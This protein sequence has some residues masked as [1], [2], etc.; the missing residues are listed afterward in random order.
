ME[1]NCIQNFFS[2]KISSDS[3]RNKKDSYDLNNK[4]TLNLKHQGPNAIIHSDN[5]FYFR[6][7]TLLDSNI[8][9]HIIA[10]DLY[11]NKTD[12]ITKNSGY[13]GVFFF[14]KKT[15]SGEIYSDRV[16][17]Y[18][19]YFQHT[20]ESLTFSNDHK[21]FPNEQVKQVDSA[22]LAEIIN[23]RIASGSHTFNPKLSQIPAAQSYHFNSSLKPISSGFYWQP[24][25]RLPVGSLSLEEASKN[26]LK[27]INNHLSKAN[28]KEKKVAVLLS[29]GVDSSLL[30]ALSKAH[31]NNIVAVTPVFTS[32]DNPELDIAKAMAASINIEHQIIEINDSDIAKEFSGVVQCLQQP[33]RSPH[34]LIFSILMKQ[35]Q[36][37]FD[38]V[39]FGEGADT[40]FGYHGIKQ[41]GKRYEKQRKVAWLK[42]YSLLLKA[43]TFIPNINKLFCLINESVTTQVTNSWS[44]D[45]LPQLNQQLPLLETISEKIEII[46]WLNLPRLNQKNLDLVA[47]ENLVRKFLIQVGNV[48]HFYNMGTIANREGIEL[49]CPFLDIE[50][51]KYAA[52]FHDKLYF[53]NGFVKPILRSMG[54]KFYRKELMY[55]KK[56]GF[57][58]PHKNWL[59]GPLLRQATEAKEFIIKN[60]DNEACKDNEFVWLIMALQELK[61]SH[62]IKH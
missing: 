3:V 20:Q 29:G 18:R 60:Y 9:D 5:F 49:I 25:D 12:I 40:I 8:T 34:A 14:N 11:Q 2:I 7:G 38:A 46:Q 48:D 39:V 4:L 27:L 45:Y 15:T 58:V 41:A 21:T 53:G 22:W 30:A 13:F 44:L 36:G 32:G 31:N 35:F 50:L 28:I 61:I 43:L 33:I 16:G 52:N 56:K 1:T 47:F 59:H 51:I 54:A 42:P 57:P 17:I 6:F 19:V 26:T 10:Q 23:F 37:K 62:A 24:D 55:L